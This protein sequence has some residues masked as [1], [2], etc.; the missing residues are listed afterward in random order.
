MIY[1]NGCSDCM[2]E[3]NRPNCH[4]LDSEAVNEMYFIYKQHGKIFKTDFSCCTGDSITTIKSCKSLP[5]FTTL[6]KT[7][8][9]K[10]TFLADA[11]N[12][13]KLP[14]PVPDDAYEDIE[15]ITGD[16]HQRFT[17]YFDQRP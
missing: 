16:K 3:V 10:N 15:L 11:S 2:V 14:A 12:S 13:G 6:D 7:F 4:C 1:V 8:A 9:D 17:L 5:Y